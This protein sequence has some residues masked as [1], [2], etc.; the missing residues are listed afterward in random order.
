MGHI[1]VNKHHIKG[2][3]LFVGMPTE[4]GNGMYKRIL[5]MEV[6]ADKTHRQE[7]AFDFVRLNMSLLDNIR[8]GDWVEIEFQLR[9]TNRPQDDGRSRWYNGIEGMSC[10]KL[11]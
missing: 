4:F 7:V 5:V 9:G 10:T 6:W 3:V 1:Q 8:I 2:K 11:E